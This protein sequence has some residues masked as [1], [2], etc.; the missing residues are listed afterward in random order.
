M[1]DST[2]AKKIMLMRMKITALEAEVKSLRKDSHAPQDLLPA[3]RQEVRKQLNQT[4]LQS[5]ES[6]DE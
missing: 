1:S 6:V 3:I 4:N 5:V 2:H